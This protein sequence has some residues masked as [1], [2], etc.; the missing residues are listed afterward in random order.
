MLCSESTTGRTH[1]GATCRD[2]GPVAARHPRLVPEQA[3]QGQEEDHPDEAT[4]ATGE[5]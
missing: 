3:V 5:G 2:D 1:E 4:D